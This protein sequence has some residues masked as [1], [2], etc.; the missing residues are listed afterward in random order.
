MTPT[1]TMRLFKFILFSF[2]SFVETLS[3]T[4]LDWWFD[5]LVQHLFIWIREQ[6][7]FT[8]YFD[9]VFISHTHTHS[10]IC[11]KNSN[12][13]LYFRQS[14]MTFI[15]TYSWRISKLSPESSKYIDNKYFYVF[16]QFQVYFPKIGIFFLERMARIS[17]M[18]RLSKQIRRK[19]IENWRTE[20]KIP[21]I[22]RAFL[23]FFFTMSN[24]KKEYYVRR[25]N[26]IKKI[27]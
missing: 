5:C 10:F 15:S 6:C 11:D 24:R 7:Q 9:D 17:H 8:K 27:D 25:G 21:I 2:G 26:S 20:R 3:R 4:E 12:A 18:T 14:V 19:H 23:L 22:L 1:T 16:I 13:L